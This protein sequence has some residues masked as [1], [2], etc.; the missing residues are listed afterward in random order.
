MSIR[1]DGCCAEIPTF[2]T[3]EL[4]NLDEKELYERFQELSEFIY[5]SAQDIRKKILV[6]IMM[7]EKC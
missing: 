6:I 5:Q 7:M 2:L 1:S 4:A 3:Y